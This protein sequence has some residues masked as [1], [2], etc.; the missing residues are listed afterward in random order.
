LTDFPITRVFKELSTREL[1]V[2][3][4]DI[5]IVAFIIYK[6]LMM[7]R[8]TRGW[9]ILLGLLVFTV[10]LT[11]S[12]VLHLETLHWILEKATLLGP[13]ALV[14]LFLPEL[15]QAL[16]GLTR[17]GIFPES[18]TEA[19]HE[20]NLDRASVEEIVGAVSEMARDRVGAIIVIETGAHMDDIADNGVKLN[21]KITTSLL[22]SVFYGQNPLHDGAVII[23][24]DHILAAACRLPL[25][26]SNRI[27]RNM[28]MRHRAA[29]GVTESHDAIALVVS[30]ER[31]TINVS[32]DGQLTPINN[33]AEL[34]EFLIR[35]T[36]KEEE[37]EPPKKTKLKG[38]L[39]SAVPMKSESKPDP[40]AEVK[41]GGK[42]DQN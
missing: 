3:A 23:R 34:R 42:S 32:Q 19:G 8:G 21:A 22:G 40:S 30:E 28:H 11:V 6:L 13:V 17:L 36:T 10:A 7:V 14:I 37:P 33:S 41:L 35:C 27:S 38:K 2:T 18:V 16:E 15:R 12:D 24:G 20:K 4:I 9:R 26:E 39:I 29:V 1:I 31:G 25:S 5:L